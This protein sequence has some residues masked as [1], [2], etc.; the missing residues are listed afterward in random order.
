MYTYSL[1]KGETFGDKKFD[2]TKDLKEYVK[3]DL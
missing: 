1:D 3:K 2:N